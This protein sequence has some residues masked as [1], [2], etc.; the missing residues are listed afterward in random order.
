VNSILP[1]LFLVKRN[2]VDNTTSV[3]N[4]QWDVT[5]NVPQVTED[6]LVT[7]NMSLEGKTTIAGKNYMWLLFFRY[8]ATTVE[9]NA[10]FGG[11]WLLL[12]VV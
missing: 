9:G 7:G 11:P 10:Y 5:G 3:R 8:S 1:R 4:Y 12:G 6:L 2:V